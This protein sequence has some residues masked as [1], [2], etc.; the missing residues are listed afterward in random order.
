MMELVYRVNDEGK[1]ELL[2]TS[3]D[4]HQEPTDQPMTEIS[5]DDWNKTVRSFMD[6]KAKGEQGNG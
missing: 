1:F 6:Q 2:S 3:T 5:W 4:T